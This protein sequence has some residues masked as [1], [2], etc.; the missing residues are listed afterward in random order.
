LPI[1]HGQ[2]VFQP[3]TIAFILNLLEAATGQKIMEVG[4]GSGYILALSVRMPKVLSGEARPVS[5]IKSG[6]IL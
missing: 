3:Y 5:A 6:T 1:G 2:T 4:L